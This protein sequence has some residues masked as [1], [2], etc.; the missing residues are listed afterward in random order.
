MSARARHRSALGAVL[1]AIAGAATLAP[2]CAL[3]AGSETITG[4]LID[5]GH[6]GATS[7]TTSS[8]TTSSTTTSSTT[9]SSTT[10]TGGAACAS[11]WLV[12]ID[13]K[14]TDVLLAVDEGS[15]HIFLAATVTG[16]VSVGETKHPPNAGAFDSDILLVRY[17]ENGVAQWSRRYG[18]GGDER[19]KGLAFS[20][21]NRV[22]AA[23]EYQPAKG[24]GF[25]CSTGVDAGAGTFAAVV[26]LDP[27]SNG[28]CTSGSDLFFNPGSVVDLAV[29]PGSSDVWTAGVSSSNTLSIGHIVGPSIH[30][31]ALGGGSPAPN[32]IAITVVDGAAV[33]AGGFSSG[34]ADYQGTASFPSSDGTDALLVRF[35]KVAPDKVYGDGGV[36]FTGAGYQAFHRVTS[37]VDAIFAVGEAAGSVDLGADAGA[38]GSAGGRDVLVVKRGADLSPLWGARFGGVGNER[39]TVIAARSGR[40]LIAGQ[41]SGGFSI[42]DPLAAH[43]GEDVFVAALD[44]AAAGAPLWACSFGGANDDLVKAL[45]AVSGGLVITGTFSGP[46][47]F[48]QAIDGGGDAIF[49]AKLTGG[50]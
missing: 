15:Q 50:S 31:P 37:D 24:H 16:E 43:G 8:T 12:K 33:L 41:H 9:T 48:G 45:R 38:L 30:G 6:G 7:T 42:A 10:T 49:V 47:N 46:A 27:T 40:V 23:I 17:D 36:A 35:K 2:A 21:S 1:A 29:A 39:G 13:G 44:D 3:I 18:T 11:S 5:A 19:V 28:D 25:G 32:P 4:D 26:A 14:A 22:I 34:F 20:T